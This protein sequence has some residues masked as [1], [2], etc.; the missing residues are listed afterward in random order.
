MTTVGRLRSFPTVIAVLGALLVPGCAGAPT[1]GVVPSPPETPGA[2]TTATPTITATPTPPTCDDRNRW[3]SFASASP[4]S[5]REC[6]EAGARLQ[7]LPWSPPIIFWAARTATDPAAIGVLTDAGADPNARV[8]EGYL[9]MYGHSPLHTAAS[10]NPNPAIVDALVAAGADVN[11]HGSDGVTPLHA[12]WRN[13]NPEVVQALLRSGADPLARDQTGRLADPTGCAN[14]NTEV[15]ARLALPPHVEQCLALGEDVNAYDGDGSTPLHLAATTRSLASVTILLEAGADVSARNNAG[16]TPL[17]LAARSSSA[18]IVAALLE[19]GADLDADAGGHGTP[20]LHALATPGSISEG[21]VNALL[22]AGADVNARDSTG[23]TPLLASMGPQRRQGS[24]TDLPMRLQALGADPN[25]R[26]SQGRTPLHA[27]AA[28]EGP[29]V[30]R[31]LLHAGAD[32][33]TLT[34]DGSSPLHAAAESGS[35]DVITLLIGAGVNADLPN[36]NAE[37]PLHLAVTETRIRWRNSIFATRDTRPTW[38]LSAF[39]LL[40]AGADPTARTAEGNTPLH[41]SLWYRDSTLVSALVEAGTDV[42]ARND[43]GETPLHVARRLGNGPAMRRLLTLGADPNARDNTG[44]IADP[45]DPVCDWGPGNGDFARLWDV[46]A[47]LPAESVEGCLEGGASVDARDEE[48]ATFLARMVSMLGCCSDFENVL[49]VLVAAG[50][51]VNA[52][53]DAGRTPLHRTFGMSSRVSQSVLTGVTSALLDAGAD[54]NAVDAQGATLLHAGPTWAVPLLGAAGA[55]L[56]TRNNA[57]ETPLH[58]ALG[59][60]DS[61]KV[62]ALLQLGADTAALDGEGNNADPVSCDRWGSGTFFA[63]ADAVVLAGCAAS[64]ADV[65]AIA[66]HNANALLF[67][68]AARARDPALVSVLLKAGGDVHAGDHWGET[69]LHSAAA[70][71]S[72]GVVRALLD[73]GS[74]PNARE[75]GFSVDYGWSWTPLHLAAASN[76]DPEVVAS[77]LEAGADLNA[78]SGEGMFPLHH[79]TANQNPAVAALLLDAG[80]DVNALSRTRRTPLHEAAANASNPAVIELLVA[81]GTDV[82]ARDSNGHTPLHTA[83]WYNDAAETVNALIAAGADVNARDPEGYVFTG[84]ARNALTPLLMA[85]WRGGVRR[86]GERRPTMSNA[87]VIEALVHAGADLIQADS[88]GRTPLHLAAQTH[89]AVFPLLLRLGADPTARDAD[90]KTPLDYA[91]DNRSLEG[92]PEVRRM[93]E[94]MRRDAGR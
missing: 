47:R 5:V 49:S 21:T 73:A 11:A 57:G 4:R 68:A 65:R 56:N 64:G 44:R 53:D 76:P 94:A 62:L 31:A 54:P 74:D 14:W 46:L 23:K 82:N 16:S 20:L 25:W 91:L 22:E 84:R 43:Q 48:G 80:A 72:A 67:R 51:D 88:S 27:A 38:I 18:E 77:L 1:A 41:L 12:A 75:A 60:D 3:G 70:K 83:A 55:E 81:A 29:D 6:L 78:I 13:R 34:N 87:A 26:D 71:G 63:L 61:E 30:I 32:P 58:A 37:A 9:R 2:V 42:N 8:V 90:G 7:D 86:G 15:F 28:T 10:L 85:T 45:V 17:H 19:A 69:P 79:A 36:D 93:R 59:R 52:R 24:A 39:T 92:L 50:A 66:S 33:L 35:P 89:P 40:D